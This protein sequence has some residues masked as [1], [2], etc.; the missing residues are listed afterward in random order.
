M[1]P[2]HLKIENFTYDLPNEN[3]AY[4]PKE[5]RDLSKLLVYKG[6][7]VSQTVYKNIAQELPEDSVLVF[8][9]TKVIKSRLFFQRPTGA[10][11]EIFCLEPYGENKNFDAFFQQKENA[12]WI[13]LVGKIGKWKEPQLHKTLE[14]N[15][16]KVTITAEIVER[17][18][19][20]FVVQFSWSS[21]EISF[22]EIINA[23]GVTPLPP[24]IKRIADKHDEE[25][26]QTVY[27]EQEGSVAAPTA[28]L[29]FTDRI[30]K[31]LEQKG[32]P[33][34]FTT[35]HVG[36]GTF[37]PVKSVTMDAHRMHA[38][39][40]CIS[41]TFLE[42]LLSKIHATIITVGTTSTRTL[43]SIYWMGN[44]IISNPEISISDLKITQW[45]P[46]EGR[47][48]FSAEK[49]VVAL[50]HWMRNK[51]MEILSIETQIIIAPSYTF[52]IVKGLITNF[53]QPQSTLLL[54]VSALVGDKWKELYQYALD[55]DFRFLSYGDGNLLL[56]TI[57][58]KIRS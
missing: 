6:G 3:I 49:S 38:E 26:Y 15:G 14:I 23:A 39:M 53:H 9:N 17:L 11:I 42:D 31:S 25:T 46:Y 4:S 40:M 22:L 51:N 54:L 28:G 34:L 7:E 47:E 37:M 29:H 41:Q 8:N 2:K 45:Q 36:A 52:G 44:K 32:I 13:C 19:D 50:L 12:K 56:P 21:S 27:S 35:L 57:Q 30:F 58:P 16:Q 33:K 43:E 10:V 48:S 55:N 1:H 18:E 5:P 20:S 24:Y